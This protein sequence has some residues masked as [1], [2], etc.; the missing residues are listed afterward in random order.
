[1]Q[2]STMKKV[3]THTTPALGTGAL[4]ILPAAVVGIDLAS[5]ESG[6]AIADALALDGGDLGD[7]LLVVIE[8]VVEALSVL[9]HKGDAH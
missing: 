7:N 8:A 9:F 6:N 3:F 5:D 1:M 4:G 2:R